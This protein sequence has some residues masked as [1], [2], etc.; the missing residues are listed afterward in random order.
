MG[1]LPRALET[2][3]E[4]ADCADTTAADCD[5]AK[6]S[7]IHAQSAAVFNLQVQPRSQLK[8]LRLAQYY[9]KRGEDTLIAIECYAQQADAYDF[10]HCYDS[11]I[12]IR[13]HAAQLFNNCGRKDR[14]AQTLG[15]AIIALLKKKDIIKAKHFIDEF[16]LTSTLVDKDGNIEKGREIYY[17]TK[18]MYYIAINRI[19]SAEFMFRKELADGNDLNNQIAGCKGLQTVYGQVNNP[20]SIAKYANLGYELNDSAYSLSEMLNIQKMQS[21]YQYNHQQLLAE[22]NARRAEQSLIWLVFVVFLFIVFVVLTYFMLQKYKADRERELAEYHLN[23]LR[24]EEAQTELLELRERSL[25]TAVLINEKTEEI[26]TLQIKI[27]GYQKRQNCYDVATLEDR[28][29]NAQIV[30]EL[31]NLLESNPVQSATQSQLRELKKF[32]NEQIPSFY[33]SLNSSRV[34][35]PVEYEVCLLTRCHFKPAAISKLLNRDDA[36]IANLRRAILQKVYGIKGSPKDL[37]DR[38]MKIV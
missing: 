27:E 37:D 18:G 17:Y 19:D 5:F 22:Q 28:I 16:E 36:Y 34:L 35:R 32:I 7:R 38:I 2:Y 31:R 21:S 8:E 33:E 3:Y 14:A 13:E 25:D 30:E 24:L 20:D 4:A 1:E 6:L 12:V 9:A 11:V 15:S 23:Q 29:A 26:K 10:L